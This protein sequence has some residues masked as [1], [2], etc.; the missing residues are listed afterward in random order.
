MPDPQFFPPPKP[1]SLAEIVAL[2]GARI[3]HQPAG[4]IVITGVAPLDTAG[5]ADIA[6]LEGVAYVAQAA[7][8][9]AGA[10][11]ASAKFVANVPASTAAL[12]VTEPGRAFAIVAARLFPTA[13]RPLA[14]SRIGEVAASAEI[15]P[16]ARLES[17]VSIGPFAVIGAEVE[18]G[19]GTIVGPGAVIGANTRIGRDCSIGP[20]TTVMHALLG[21]RVIIHPGACIGQDG[22]GYVPGAKGHMKIPQVGRV[23]IQ[24]DVE[25]GAN[26]TID[27]GSIRDTLIGE[28]TKIDNLVQ[29]GHNTVIGRHCFLAGQVGISGSVT[30]GDYAALG[31]SAGV[32]PHVSIGAGASI[33]AKSAV[34]RD[35]PPGARWGG[36]PARPAQEWIRSQSA[37]LRASRGKAKQGDAGKEDK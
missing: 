14:F 27:R 2:T 28:G 13:T 37:A 16:T 21:N 22:F 18:I 25:I 36:Y 11:F 23:V 1:L 9:K 15:D 20:S 24:D 17:G 31:G 26:S 7:A 32:G 30:I 19:Q 4:E 12:E 3:V 6:F 10:C 35:V 5:P 29:V 8:T 33:A 34:F